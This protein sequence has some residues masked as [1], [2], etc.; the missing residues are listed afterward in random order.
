MDQL[1]V[2]KP[3][4]VLVS[5]EDSLIFSSNYVQCSWNNFK[6]NFEFL[7]PDADIDAPQVQVHPRPPDCRRGRG[8]IRIALQV[9]VLRRQSCT[10]NQGSFLMPSLFKMQKQIIVT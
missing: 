5:C 3:N 4:L 6:G 8:V 2:M 9:R 1:I 7:P 10:L